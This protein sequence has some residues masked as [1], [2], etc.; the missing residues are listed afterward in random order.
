MRAFHLKQNEID[1]YKSEYGD[2]WERELIK[3]GIDIHKKAYCWLCKLWL[4]RS[5]V[6]RHN[7][8][9]HN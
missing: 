9:Y 1:Y 6:K 2:D 3:L 8:I 4:S 5:A 7:S